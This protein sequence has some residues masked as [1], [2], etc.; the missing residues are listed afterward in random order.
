VDYYKITSAKRAGVVTIE[1]DFEPDNE[2]TVSTVYLFIS[3]LSN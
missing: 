2:T 3:H 1:Y